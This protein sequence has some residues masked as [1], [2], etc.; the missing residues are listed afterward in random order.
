VV[1]R[2][3]AAGMNPPL[4]ALDL[5]DHPLIIEELDP[6]GMEERR[7]FLVEIAAGLAN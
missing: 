1:Y 5:R 3:P 6:A 4:Q 7:K 2:V